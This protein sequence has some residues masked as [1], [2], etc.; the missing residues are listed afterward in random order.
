MNFSKLNPR[1]WFRREDPPDPK[2]VGFPKYKPGQH[3]IVIKYPTW[4]SVI[5]QEVILNEPLNC[6]VDSDQTTVVGNWAWITDTSRIVRLLDGTQAQVV[7]P[8]DW[9]MPID[10][11]DVNEELR[12]EVIDNFGTSQVEF[13]RHL[14]RLD[15]ALE[16]LSEVVRRKKQQAI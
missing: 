1:N 5:G 3:C 15:K 16:D 14:A 8:E 4:Q 2:A 10:D 9:L 11:E 12:N 7:F 13:D 6:F